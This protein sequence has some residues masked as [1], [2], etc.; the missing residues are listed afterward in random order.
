MGFSLGI[1]V[2]GSRIMEN[3]TGKR[4]TNEM[5]A[6]TRW[7]LIAFGGCMGFGVGGLGFRDCGVKLVGDIGFGGVG[8]TQGLGF[9]PP[10]KRLG[11]LHRRSAV[12]S[13]LGSQ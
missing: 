13:A 9:R 11:A 12:D 2:E 6:R 10:P 1:G 7:G 4:M 8:A 5:E 3:Q